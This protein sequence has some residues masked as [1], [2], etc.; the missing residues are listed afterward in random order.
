MMMNEFL[1]STGQP[2]QRTPLTALVVDDDEMLAEYVAIELS[3]LGCEAACVTSGEAALDALDDSIDVLVTDWQMPGMDG[4]ELVRRIRSGRH[5]LAPIHIAMMTAIEDTETIRRAM[6]AGV[7]TFLYKPVEPIQLELAI[8]TARR[9]RL[10][11]AKL[12][13][14]NRLL[15]SAHEKAKDALR[16]VRA[17]LEA[18][19]GLHERLLPKPDRLPGV[20]VAHVYHPAA[21]LGGDTIGAAAVGQGRTLFFLIDVRGHGVPSALDSFHLHHRLKA[22]RPDEPDALVAAVE[23]L[24]E[25]M[26]DRD[27]ESYATMIAGLVDPQQERGW[28]VRAGHPPAIHVGGRTIDVLE[29]EGSF[30]L[31]WFANTTFTASE[32]SFS[33]RDR[34]V[35]YSDGLT[36]CT[37]KTGRELGVPRLA[38][39]ME[40]CVGSDISSVTAVVELT[41]KLRARAPNLADDVSLLAIE[42]AH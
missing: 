4:M 38:K 30:P 20:N 16:S 31:G 28:L 39:L 40:A 3:A 22:L 2:Q 14:R 26:L 8:E 17:D 9:N 27:D 18:A 12:E 11:H 5:R 25:E 36:E 24:N 6:Q 41:L 7:D 13:R 10:L 15:A 34:L 32:F 23:R 33:A 1:P 21:R 29:D 19:A 42:P 35:I 37:D